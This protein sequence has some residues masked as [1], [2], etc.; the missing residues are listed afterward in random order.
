M[1]EEGQL[2]IENKCIANEQCKPTRLL[3]VYQFQM[4]LKRREVIAMDC[5]CG[6]ADLS[7]KCPIAVLR[8]MDA[9]TFSL[10]SSSPK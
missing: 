6:D 3:V 9:D 8:L 2:Y 1:A 10:I 4:L 5:H 7:A